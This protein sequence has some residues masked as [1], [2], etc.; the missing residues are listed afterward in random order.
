MQAGSTATALT[1]ATG[2]G[3]QTPVPT[4]SALSTKAPTHSPPIPP[5][6][7]LSLSL[8]LPS[9]SLSLGSL[10]LRTHKTY[11]WSSESVQASSRCPVRSWPWRGPWAAVYVYSSPSLTVRRHPCAP[12][13]PVPGAVPCRTCDRTRK[14]I[15]C[16]VAQLPTPEGCMPWPDTD[17]AQLEQVNCNRYPRS[18]PAPCVSCACC[19]PRGRRLMRDNSTSPPLHAQRATSKQRAPGTGL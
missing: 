9:L 13:K 16:A 18:A 7:S 2:K 10:S 1:G 19:V 14:F 5:S 12:A 4:H 6:L 3:R 11:S 15:S 8:S 17:D